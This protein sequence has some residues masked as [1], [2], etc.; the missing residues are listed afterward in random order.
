MGQVNKA[1]VLHLIKDQGPISRAAV[2]KTLNMSRST[3]SS[4]VDQLIREGR[5]REGMTGES[6]S[7]GGRRPVDL[8]YVANA[9]FALGVDIGATKTIAL[10]TDLTGNVIY[11]EKFS[12]HAQGIS[13]MA[14]IYEQLTQFVR[15]VGIPRQ[16]IIGTAIGFPGVT[17]ANQGAVVEAN[18]L[19]LRNFSAKDFFENLPNPI[20]ID[21]DVN[22]AVIG[23]RWKGAAIG[24]SNVVLVAIGSGIGA[25]LILDDRIYRGANSFAGEL[26]HLQIDP[27]Q[28]T[29]KRNLGDYGPLEQ[30]ASGKGME[31]YAQAQRKNYPD[32]TLTNEARADEIFAAAE[33]GDGLA[34]HVI[35]RAIDYLSFAIANMVTLLNPDVVI[36]GG[37]VARAGDPLIDQ[38]QAGVNRLSP[39]QCDITSAA[40][41]EDAAAYGSAATVL[42]KAG[43]LRLTGFDDW[44][45]MSESGG[46]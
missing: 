6:T 5:V 16:N 28:T 24:R 38:I 9:R 33:A 8:H 3:I 18:H 34:K 42:L 10:L 4:I 21:N 2:A 13:P 25:G 31:D 37:G 43:E 27:K 7:A 32:T 12:S 14:H 39:M 29:E 45:V 35:Q 26:G 22:M 30:V 20:W 17:L 15:D 1:N 40:L 41:G 44:Q 11:R 36:I 46:A 23:E 19:K